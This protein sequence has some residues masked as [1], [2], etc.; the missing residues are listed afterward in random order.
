MWARPSVQKLSALPAT[1]RFKMNSLAYPR[2]GDTACHP[3]AF[4]RP[5]NSNLPCNFRVQSAF[6]QLYFDFLTRCFRILYYRAAARI[7]YHR[8]T[9]FQYIQRVHYRQLV[10]YNCKLFIAVLKPVIQALSQF[11][12]E[13]IH[14]LDMVIIYIKRY[15]KTVAFGN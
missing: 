1:V 13:F 12:A 9:F 10:V 8:V 6:I 5:P 11:K 4:I 3:Y 2:A 15:L 14:T 7:I